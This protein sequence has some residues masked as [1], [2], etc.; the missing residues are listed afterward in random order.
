VDLPGTYYLQVVEQ[1]FK[2]NRLASG[3]FIALGRRIDLSTLR[4]PVFLLAG[5]DDDVA[6]PAQVFATEQLVDRAYCRVQKATALCGHLGLFMGRD[7]LR[8][9]WPDIARWLQ[10]A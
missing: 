4:C 2:E 5:R 7:N 1:L 8:T 6:A 10:A 9:A 3:N